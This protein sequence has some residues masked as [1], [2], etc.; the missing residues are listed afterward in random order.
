[1]ALPVENGRTHEPS[2]RELTVD[3]DG[4]KALLTERIEGLRLVMDE[5]HNLYKERAD[6]Q[7]TAVDD[8]LVAAKEKTEAAF[9]ASKEAIVK[10]E[11]SQ[12]AY[13]VSH[14]DLLKKQ[15]A[16]M[17]RLEVDRIVLSWQ[18][19]LDDLKDEV[20]SLRESRSESGGKQKTVEADRLQRNVN[21]ALLVSI[22]GIGATVIIAL[23]TLL[24]H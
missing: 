7:K 3:L 6:S 1:M 22:L 11:N 23:I 9:A 21:V 13:N 4:V 16:M 20:G 2:L 24:R 18:E 10:A 17:P 15:D 12:T 5:R 14:N 19:K 8:A